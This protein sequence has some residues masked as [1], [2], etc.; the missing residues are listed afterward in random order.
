MFVGEIEGDW[1]QLMASDEVGDTAELMW[2]GMV[3]SVKKLT[4]NVNVLA[5]II[6]SARPE[7]N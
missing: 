3:L 1:N 2:M 4:G 7:F 5:P 6:M